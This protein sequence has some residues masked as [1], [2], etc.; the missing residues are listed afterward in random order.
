MTGGQLLIQEPDLAAFLK[1]KLTSTVSRFAAR[2]PRQRQTAIGASELGNPCDRAL[3]WKSLGFT[4]D[5]A[6]NRQDPWAAFLGTAVHARLEK[7][8]HEDNVQNDDVHFTVNWHIETSVELAPGIRGTADLYDVETQTVID[9][10]VPADSVY[11]KA[12]AGDINPTYYVQIQAYG[13]GFAAAGFD[14]KN[15][16]I[17]FWPRGTGARLSALH[18]VTWPY[19]RAVTENA[20]NRWY[21][22]VGAAIDLDLE[23]YPQR[24]TL[25]A[26]ADGP[27]RWCPFFDLTGNRP[28]QGMPS[29][30][31]HKP[32]K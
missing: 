29:C 19:D 16:A 7:V 6:V 30:K 17:A 24:G 26:T 9:H 11:K 5:A 25:L 28:A 31:G 18:V 12:V 22:L 32:R 27:C 1:T 3:A 21:A 23:H 14:V 2:Q 8:F 10:K 4:G 20:L 15:V 13:Y